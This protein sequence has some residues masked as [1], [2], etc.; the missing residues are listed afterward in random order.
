MPRATTLQ[1]HHAWHLE[2]RATPRQCWMDN[3]KEWTFLPR[4]KLLNMASS[5]KTKKK[6]K[7]NL[8]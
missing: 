4:P 7:Q 2:G 5:Q 1:N 8:R 3:I 6:L